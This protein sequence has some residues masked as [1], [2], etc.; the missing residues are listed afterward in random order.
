MGK[1]LTDATG[2]KMLDALNEQ[3]A[4]LQILAEDKT[5]TMDL[6]TF[7]SCQDQDLHRRCLALETR[8]LLNGQTK[9]RAKLTKY[10]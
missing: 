3:N 4:L 6:K 2:L 7:K 10:L 9:H 5:A 1:I 8:S